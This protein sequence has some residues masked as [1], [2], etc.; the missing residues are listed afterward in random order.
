MEKY[1]EKDGVWRTI[2][3]RRVFIA[4]GES[5]SSAMQKSGK[6]SRVEKNKNLYEKRKSDIDKE[7]KEPSALRH[8][9]A[10]KYGESA[11][12]FRK[13][14]HISQK[15]KNRVAKDEYK[16]GDRRGLWT[17]D[18]AER[19]QLKQEQLQKKLA[20]YKAKKQSNNKIETENKSFSSIEFEK[21]LPHEMRFKETY[22]VN[23][24]K[25]LY[26]VTQEPF[27]NEMLNN[28]AEEFKKQGRYEKAYITTRDFS[29]YDYNDDV[30]R[31]T[32]AVIDKNGNINDN[33]YEK[34]MNNAGWEY[35]KQSNNKEETFK[36]TSTNPFYEDREYN[37]EQLDK[38][39][40]KG[41]KPMKNSYSGQGWEGTKYDS[42]LSTK[43]IA[44]NISDYSKKEFPDVKL[45]RKTDYNSI[46]VHIM[47]SDK[48]LYVT[49]KDIDKMSDNQVFDTIHQS[50]GGV[51]RLD[52]WLNKNNRKSKEGTYTTNDAREYL[53]EEL[54]T[55]RNR[56]GDNVSGS[57]WYLS[58]YGKKVVSGLNKEMNSYNFD[59][60]DAYTDYFNSNFYGYVKIGKW[61]APYQV[62]DT[63]AKIDA[64]KKRKGK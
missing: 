45:S 9:L 23:D 16:A 34:Q 57:E 36:Q 7:S 54:N 30:K 39:A 33:G 40:E 26:W 41:I 64:Y 1:E 48:D 6:F 37:K 50:I 60:D 27:T 25:D 53:K 22:S 46:D 4:K 49:S 2:R 38:M 19:Q 47:S 42:N 17:T 35:K 63:K 21:N 28:Y 13:A 5:L 14:K 52:D 3:G 44:K 18:K 12:E 10:Y 59:D 55:Y 8:N 32:L 29:G 31:N 43:E 20:D 11:S 62:N 56:K 15:E 58:D 24:G 61:D 51:G